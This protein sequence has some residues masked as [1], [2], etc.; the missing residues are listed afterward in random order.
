MVQAPRHVVIRE[1]YIFTYF[2]TRREMKS[3]RRLRRARPLLLP[4]HRGNYIIGIFL[5]ELPKARAGMEIKPEEPMYIVYIIHTAT[6]PLCYIYYYTVYRR[7]STST[8]VASTAATAT[9]PAWAATLLRSIKSFMQ[10]EY[11][12]LCC[13]R[14]NRIKI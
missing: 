11:R 10:S 14:D 2:R 7:S 8:T 9:A 12:R 13:H 6:T 4:I 3:R 5:R 1:L